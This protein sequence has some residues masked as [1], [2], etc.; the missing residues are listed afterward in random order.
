MGQVDDI[1][2]MYVINTATGLE[3]ITNPGMIT[4][5][6]VLRQDQNSEDNLEF[7]LTLTVTDHHVSCREGNV[8]CSSTDNTVCSSRRPV[9]E[10]TNYK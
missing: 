5:P 4:T 3:Y 10:D 6:D 1:Q 8:L 9:G 2:Y 7:C